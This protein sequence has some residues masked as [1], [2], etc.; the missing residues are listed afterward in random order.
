[1]LSKMTSVWFEV[2]ST[3]DQGRLSQV[4]AQDSIVKGLK[5]GLRLYL[6]PYLLYVSEKA[7]A[8]MCPR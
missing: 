2:S 1:M 6:H 4:C 7:L 5:L 8:S 3:C